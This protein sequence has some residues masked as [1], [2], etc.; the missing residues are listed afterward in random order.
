MLCNMV[1][2]VENIFSEIMSKVDQTEVLSRFVNQPKINIP[3]NA[4]FFDWYKKILT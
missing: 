1:D 2:N 3:L 4:D